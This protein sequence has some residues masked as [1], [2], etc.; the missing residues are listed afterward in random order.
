LTLPGYRRELFKRYVGMHEAFTYFIVPV[1]LMSVIGVT[2]ALL[3]LA[4]P[5]LWLV[6]F[7]L[8]LYGKTL[9]KV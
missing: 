1:M 3:L 4:I 6:G 8:I 9:P 2:S 7:T 5:P